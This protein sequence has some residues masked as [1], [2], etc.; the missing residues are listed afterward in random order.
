MYNTFMKIAS[1]LNILSAMVI[2][3]RA[4]VSLNSDDRGTSSRN[5]HK[6]VIVFTLLIYLFTPASS[7][8]FCFQEAGDYYNISPNLLYV[9][10]DAESDFDPSAKNTNSD[11]SY[12]FGLMQINS[13]WADKIGMDT[14]L[15]LG[16]PCYNVY[17]GAWIL[18]DCFARY[19]YT[20]KGIGCYNAKSERKR[21]AYAWKIY[22]LLVDGTE[23]NRSW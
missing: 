17:V 8:A 1:S 11:G 9:I 14:W 20:W 16:D 18:S 15:K 6:T 7:Y 22:R 3:G 4:S 2:P 21:V 19:G 23:E 12:D 5:M 13:S 10:A